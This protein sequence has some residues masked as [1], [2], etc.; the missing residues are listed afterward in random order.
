MGDGEIKGTAQR[1]GLG[2]RN[3]RG[4]SSCMQGGRINGDRRTKPIGIKL[5]T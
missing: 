2:E 4:V 1:F 3:D 5:T